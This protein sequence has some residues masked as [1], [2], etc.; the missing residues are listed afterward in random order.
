[1]SSHKKIV[2]VIG[3]TGAQ[4]GSVVAALLKDPQYLVRAITRNTNSAS[5]KAL[6]NK[7]VEVVQADANS[8]ESLKVAF[9][10]SYVIYAVTDFFEPFG[11]HGPTE[12]IKIESTQGINLAKAALATHT[13]EH[14]IWSTL[15]DAKTISGGKYMV[16]HF[17]S[18]NIVDRWIR[19]QPELIKKTTFFWVTFYAQNMLWDPLL[20]IHV[21]SANMYVQVT[22][23]SGKTPIVSIG[24]ASANV[25]KFVAAA[26]ARP[27]HT[28]NGAV[29]L[30][31]ESETTWEEHLQFW[32]KAQ[33]KKAR[34]V[35][36]SDEDL[37][38]LWPVLGNEI[39]LMMK[40]WEEAGDRSWEVP[41]GVRL[42]TRA[43]LGVSGLV[44]ATEAFKNM[45]ID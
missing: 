38:S 10:G 11:K 9:A 23:I 3:A 5:A 29:V 34:Q 39:N 31:S 32:A 21:P 36:I 7:G 17:E 42:F 12:A 14:Y 40:F 44:N 19:S 26:I 43:E 13:L 1:M 16:P 41:K 45:K 2:S 24:D 15:A 18:K 8:L 4:G 27:N 6:A 22:N 30:A 35:I 25:G 20:P 33:G 28:R 37:D